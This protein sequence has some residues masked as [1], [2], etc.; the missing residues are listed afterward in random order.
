MIIHFVVFIYIL[1]TV[2]NFSKAFQLHIIKAV[3]NRTDRN[4]LLNMEG[5]IEL[6][7]LKSTRKNQ[8]LTAARVW[9]CRI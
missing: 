5:R 1:L 7:P 9:S 4:L 8:L 3:E 2:L 6:E